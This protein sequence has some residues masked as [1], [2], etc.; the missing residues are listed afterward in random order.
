MHT[1]ELR[2]A[3]ALICS[4][5]SRCLLIKRQ[6]K[7]D[8]EIH[9]PLWFSR[10]NGGGSTVYEQQAPSSQSSNSLLSRRGT[11]FS[12]LPQKEELYICRP[13]DSVPQHLLPPLR[14]HKRRTNSENMQRRALYDIPT[15][16]VYSI[17]CQ[18]PTHMYNLN[19]FV[20]KCSDM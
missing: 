10:C 16:R 7:I 14:S 15:H 1:H 3:T 4:T 11:N 2:N 9:H 17:L 19:K 20:R 13:L 5:A 8:K 12:R 6:G 18:T